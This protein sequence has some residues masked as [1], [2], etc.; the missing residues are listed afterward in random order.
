MWLNTSSQKHLLYSLMSIKVLATL[1]LHFN[2]SYF[3]SNWISEKNCSHHYSIFIIKH[4]I[5]FF[6]FS[7]SSFSLFVSLFWYKCVWDMGVFRKKF[8][9]WPSV[10][11]FR[12]FSIHIFSYGKYYPKRKA[13]S[14]IF[15][16]ML[17][18]L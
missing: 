3:Y 9:K 7:F 15:K 8:K 10:E 12:E 11:Y 4:F 16:F 14:V 18:L 13:C 2:I 5:F 1:N 17:L 6:F